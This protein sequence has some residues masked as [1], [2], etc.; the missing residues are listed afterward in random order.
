L[1]PE[2][3]FGSN[4]RG[5]DKDLPMAPLG[6]EVPLARPDDNPFEHTD[7][8]IKEEETTKPDQGVTAYSVESKIEKDLKKKA[9]KN[10][11]VYRNTKN[12]FNGY[13]VPK[14]DPGSYKE[15]KKVRQTLPHPS[16]FNPFLVLGSRMVPHEEDYYYNAEEPEQD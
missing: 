3:G 11:I 12:H 5:Y 2:N 8:A 6:P 4:S 1:C 14:I 15:D 13:P 9:Q 10:K 16:L 7:G